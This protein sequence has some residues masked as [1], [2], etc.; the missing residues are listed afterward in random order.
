ME[1]LLIRNALLVNE[2]FS[3]YA[4]VF[5]RKGMIEKIDRNGIA[6]QADRVIEASGCWLF[7]GVIDDQVHFRE[8]GLTHKG[9]IASESRAAVAGGVTSYMEMPNT[10][11]NAVTLPLLED[12]YEIARTHSAANYSFYLGATNNNLEELL[13]ADGNRICGIKIFM[14]SSTGN[15]LVDE[16]AAL[17]KI[18]ANVDLLIATHCEDDRMIQANLERY[19][20][21]A[22]SS[23]TPAMHPLI[24]SAEACYASSSAAVA[25]AR[26]HGTRLH[27]LHISTA[28]ELELFEKNLPLSQRKVTAEACIHH[29]WFTDADYA[30]LGNYLKW[31]P[32]VKSA[33][34]RQALRDALHTGQISVVATDH[35]PH[36]IEEKEQPYVQAPSGGPLVQHSLLAMLE[37]VNQDVLTKERVAT[38]MCHQVAE[39]FDIDRRGF[40]REGYFADLVLV[41]PRRNQTVER[42]NL[43]YHCGWSPFE[44]VTFHSKI[45]HTLVNGVVA[46]EDGVIRESNAGMRLQFNR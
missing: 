18:F 32:A 33:A 25:L 9:T 39:L 23:L 11:P 27:V 44:G 35:A 30:R 8:P 14:G 5:I 40:I 22:E 37:L 1:S 17:E 46:Y 19:R 31:N 4:D 45:T 38:L 43:L 12:K 7:P 36:T 42:K 15:M 26:R 20:S 29:L 16:P 21:E 41:D 34:D 3:Y 28:K 6:M 24:R 2:G 10:V 13:R